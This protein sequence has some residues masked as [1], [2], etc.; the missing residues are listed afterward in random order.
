MGSGRRNDYG[1]DHGIVGWECYSFNN[2]QEG[3]TEK[4]A[5]EQRSESVR[6]RDQRAIGVIRKCTCHVREDRNNELLP[7]G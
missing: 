3:L 2:G 7:M 6:E 4:V 1:G 5:S